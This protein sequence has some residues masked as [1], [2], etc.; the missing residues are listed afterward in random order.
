MPHMIGADVEELRQLADFFRQRAEQLGTL[1]TQLAGRIHSAPWRGADVDHFKYRWDRSYRATLQAAADDLRAASHTLLGQADQQRDA[2]SGAGGST[3]GGS[4][5]VAPG[6]GSGPMVCRDPESMLP[7]LQTALG[8]DESAQAAWWNSLTPAE[9]T[10]LMTLYPGL[11]LQLGVLSADDRDAAME[12]FAEY[13]RDN[14]L[15]S[16]EATGFDVTASAGWVRI[17]VDGEAQMQQMGDG[18]YRVVLTG[19]GSLGIGADGGDAEAS[20]DLSGDAS[21]TYAFDSQADADRFINDL[22]TAAVPDDLGDGFSLA[23]NAPAY[24]VNKYAEV[25]DQ[26]SGHYV[27]T[28]LTGSVEGSVEVSAGGLSADVSGSAG[29]SYDTATGDKTF[30]LDYGLGASNT[31]DGAASSIAASGSYQLTVDDSGAMTNLTIE[32]TA[33]GSAGIGGGT[34]ALNATMMAGSDSTVTTSVDLRN[35]VNQHLAAEYVNAVT[36]GDSARVNDI[37]TQLQQNSTVTVRA[38]LTTT[39]HAGFDV[40]AVEGNF[41]HSTSDLQS[42]YVKAPGETEYTEVRF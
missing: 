20:L 10:A 12:Q 13:T 34:D 21:V 2:S 41:D 42:M 6:G 1:E 14:T 26:Y 30:S 16:S 8:G 25:F 19:G 15:V 36:V 37:V 18:T 9:R 35:P 40:W 24:V 33:G 32:T 22:V 17:G 5:T 4:G 7:D 31:S 27:T 11:I 28:N 3:G 29:V 38:D 23:S 39:D